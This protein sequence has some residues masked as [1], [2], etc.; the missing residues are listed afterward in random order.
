MESRMANPS[1]IIAESLLLKD[2]MLGYD[3]DLLITHGMNVVTTVEVIMSSLLHT[4][5]M[6]SFEAGTIGTLFIMPTTKSIIFRISSDAL[7]FDSG[8]L[9]CFRCGGLIAGDTLPSFLAVA[10]AVRG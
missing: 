2:R 8:A 4:S 7:A 5:V 1:A 6:Y 3:S 10:P 9:W